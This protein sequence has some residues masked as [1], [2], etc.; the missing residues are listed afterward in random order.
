VTDIQAEREADRMIARMKFRR[1][2]VQIFYAEWCKHTEAI[3][4]DDEHIRAA[5][6]GIEA[7]LS[8]IRKREWLEADRMRGME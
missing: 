3:P 8:E 7:V 1:E 6:S 2:L 5:T 4:W